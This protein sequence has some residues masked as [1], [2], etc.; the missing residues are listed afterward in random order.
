LAL[1]A[2][3]IESIAALSPQAKGRIERLFGTLQDR[4]IAELGSRIQGL[5][6]AN[7]FLKVFIPRFNR[8]FAILPENLKKLGVRCPRARSGSIH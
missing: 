6:S 7:R 4:L 5:E 3:G 8:R 1:Q 2:L